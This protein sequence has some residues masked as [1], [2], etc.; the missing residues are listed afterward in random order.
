VIGGYGMFNI[1]GPSATSTLLLSSPT[2]FSAPE[3]F[4]DETGTSSVRTKA[5]DVYA[6]A[7]VTLEVSDN[8]KSLYTVDPISI[9]TRFYLNLNHIIIYPQNTP[10]SS[11]FY[12]A[13][14]PFGQI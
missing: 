7:M 14:A 6:F 13:V 4:S 9:M 12:R 8:L 5:G 11:I 3:Y 1:L 2:R 10:F